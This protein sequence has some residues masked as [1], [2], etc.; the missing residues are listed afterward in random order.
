MTAE[1]E[2]ADQA[3]VA[4]FLA[5][6]E[7]HGLAPGET[8]ERIDTHGAMVFLAGARVYKVKRAVRFPYMDFSTLELRRSACEREIALN[9]RTA[10]ALYLGVVTVTRGKGGTL[11][12]GGSGEII[13]YAVEMQ[14]FEQASLFD[15]MAQSS[16]LSDDHLDQLAGAIAEFHAA[17]EISHDA[18]FGG[19][20]GMAWVIEENY[21]EHQQFPGLFPP[22]AAAALDQSGHA[23]LAAVSKLLEARRRDGF[24]RHCHGDLHLRNICLLDGKPTLFDTIEFNDALAVID[25]LYDLAF[26]LMDFEHRNM[27]PAANR[28]FNRY[29]GASGDFAGLAALPLFMSARAG[30]RAKTGAVQ[31]E[32]LDDQTAAH[33]AR[34]EARAYL[35]LAAN[36]LAVEKPRL[37]AVGGLSGSGKTTLARRLAPLIGHAPGALHIRSDVIRKHLFDWH[38]T[39]PL[40]PEGYTPDANRRVYGEMAR[41]AKA[42]LAGG[43]AVVTDA[44]FAKQAERAEMAELAAEAGV[45]FTGFWL[46][47]PAHCLRER[48]TGRHNDASDATPAILR[49][50]LDYDLGEMAWQRLDSSGDAEQIAVRAAGMFSSP[51]DLPDNANKINKI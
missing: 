30:V 13:E 45:P 14:R 24:V 37:I 27:R 18:A 1:V 11:H 41:H 26:L 22:E 33:E 9:R 31:A 43:Y 32:A 19:R 34:S 23:A 20:D 6:P 50:Q 51:H 38:E 4:E 35:G 28:V 12:L 44:V 46:D 17:A 25:T 10:P 42:G 5:R 3:A 49:Q 36:L 2:S 15:R 7:S 48:I 16:S 39:T 21:Q 40:G 8:V 47:A 29:L